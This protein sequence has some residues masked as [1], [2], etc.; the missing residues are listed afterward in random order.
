MKSGRF[1][2]LATLSVAASLVA[3]YFAAE[4]YH[5]TRTSALVETRVMN[6]SRALLEGGDSGDFFAMPED[7]AGSQAPD[8]AGLNR[9]GDLVAIDPLA[10][11]TFVPPLLSKLPGTANFTTRAHYARGTVDIRTQLEYTEGAWHLLSYELI[12]GPGVM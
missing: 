8:I 3:A 9:F 12:P 5:Q 1:R 2:I 7:A 4:F 11:E 6:A 10:G